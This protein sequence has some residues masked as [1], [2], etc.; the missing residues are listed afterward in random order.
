MNFN[1]TNPC[2]Q[3]QQLYN[4]RWITVDPKNIDNDFNMDLPPNPGQSGIYDWFLH[5]G[6]LL[7]HL[8][9]KQKIYLATAHPIYDVLAPDNNLDPDNYD[10]LGT[11]PKVI[12]RDCIIH[13]VPMVFNLLDEGS[14]VHYE[15]VNQLHQSA[16]KRGIPLEQIY[17]MGSDW[18]EKTAYTKKYGPG[19][20]NIFYSNPFPSNIVRKFHH[21]EDT[22]NREDVLSHWNGKHYFS[23][24]ARK[25]RPWKM[26]AMHNIV[27]SP[28]LHERGL[29]SLATAGHDTIIPQDKSLKDPAEWVDVHEN[30]PLVEALTFFDVNGLQITLPRDPDDPEEFAQK[31]LEIEQSKG[32]AWTPWELMTDVYNEVLFD[33]SIETYQCSHQMFVTEKTFKP[34]MLKVPV[35]I[36]G[37]Q[38]INKRL[39]ELGFKTYED[40]FDLSFDDEPN[41]ATRIRKLRQEL[42]RVCTK[43]SKRSKQ[44][45]IAWSMQNQ[46]VLNHNQKLLQ[47]FSLLTDGFKQAIEQI[48]KK[49][50]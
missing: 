38:G 14:S 15:V 16:V 9:L 8:G 31:M 2:D 18:D 24:L 23:A 49:G 45:Q 17:Y 47:D 20:I 46:E 33:V 35:V 32:K 34:I 36:C 42:I 26:V 43:L 21:I 48:N 12:I 27:T 10:I 40:W 50:R 37:S 25:P 7:V 30:D 44:E 1:M 39:S 28:I 11:T 22:Y 3:H 13:K 5:L 6:K 19:G 29:K 4:V 41:T